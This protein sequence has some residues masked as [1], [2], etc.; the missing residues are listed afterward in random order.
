MDITVAICTYNRCRLLRNALESLEG[1]RIPT[2]LAWEVLVVDNGS[3]DETP[4]VVDEFADSL[5]LRRVEEPRG[6]VSHAR[7]RSVEAARGDTIIW[8]DDDVEL[9]PGWLEAYRE[10]F[11]R[12]PEAAFFGGP[13]RPRFTRDPPGWLRE[14]FP[15]VSEPF[16]TRELG[17]RPFE[18]T[19]PE[20]LPTGGNYA[21]RATVH[22]GRRY[23]AEL[24]RSGTD[25]VGGEETE[26]LRTLLREGHTGRWVPGAEVHHLIE[27]SQMNLRYVRRRYRGWGRYAEYERLREGEK[28][29]LL[30]G[31]PRWA[32]RAAFENEV[33]YRLF[34]PFVAPERWLS[35]LREASHAQGVLLGP[36]E[37][38][39]ERRDEAG[40]PP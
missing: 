36:P 20:E 2:D 4:S 25:L 7:N 32:W 27:P 14:G 39:E 17:D 6:G 8:I 38:S 18:I 16:P 26:L 35:F 23:N 12:W 21:V 1:I 22:R 33:K 34:R 3:T 15:E 13:V 19:E 24:G 5:P 28:V 29:P 9:S 31:R 11:E 10:A 40:V 37:R 30:W